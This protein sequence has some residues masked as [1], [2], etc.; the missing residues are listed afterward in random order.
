[1]FEWSKWCMALWWLRQNQTLWLSDTWLSRWIF[2]E[3][4]M[5]NVVRSNNNPIVPAALDLRAI[6][7]QGLCPNL[8]K[9]DGD[10]AAVYWFLTGSNLSF[11]YGAS[12][13]NQRIENWRLHFKLSFSAWVIDYF[14][15]IVH[16]G[17]FV[18]GNIVNIECIWF[19]YANFLQCKLDE[20]KNRMES[21][22]NKI[23]K[24]MSSFWYSQ[25]LILPT[26]I[27]RIITSGSSAQWNRHC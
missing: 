7:E 23:Y 16:Y 12:H 1:M 22:C 18:P 8:L 6:K 14:K 27:K 4:F 24:R 21:S 20:V 25:S 26:W 10:I 9:T 13:V 2:K 17:I 11:R 5:V 3:N 15:Q 19:V